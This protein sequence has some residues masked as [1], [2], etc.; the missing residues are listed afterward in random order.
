MLYYPWYNEVQDLLG[1]YSTYEVHY[2]RVHSIVVNNESKYSQADVK[3]VQIDE[4]KVA[5]VSIYGATL[6]T[7]ESRSH[8]LS[9]GAELLTEV[10]REDLQSN[11]NGLT[12]SASAKLC[13]RF[14]SAANMQEIPLY[15]AL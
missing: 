1:S 13:V 3:N 14:D 11:A 5:P 10:S 12:S 4:M 2:Q 6:S 8:P 15:F 9:E 7:E